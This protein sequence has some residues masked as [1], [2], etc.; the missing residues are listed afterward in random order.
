M[1]IGSSGTRATFLKFGAKVRDKAKQRDAGVEIGTPT[2]ATLFPQL[3]DTTYD[4]SRFMNYFPAGY[5]PFPGINA[6]ASRALFAALPA[7]S[8][9][10]DRGADAESY[11]ADER[12]VAAYAMAELFLGPKLTIVPG[13]RFESTKVNY[14][15]NEVLFDADGDYV[16]TLPLTGGDTYGFAL[17]GLHLRYAIDDR[18]NVR[19]AYTRTLARPNYFDLVPYELVL[20]EDGDI[21]RGNS[22]LRPTT[23]DNLDFMVEHYFASV[24][25]VSGGVF[26]KRLN[27]YIYQFRFQEQNF[28]ELYAVTQPQNGER[29]NL[30]GIEIAFQNRLTFLPGALNGIS[31][32]GNYTFTTSSARFPD[33][34][35][36]SRLPGQSQHLGNLAISYEKSGFTGKA[37]LN[38][39]GRYIDAVGASAAEDVSYD[40]HT[41]LDL[42]FG[43]RLT[44]NIR[45][46]ADVLNLTNAPL[47][48]YIG[49]P[50]RPIQEE[51]YRWWTSFGVKV[52][53]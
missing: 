16:S 51:Y 25:V 9:V 49:T 52:N 41:Q 6:A 24:G 1:P 42:N 38:F 29:A 14:V 45:V 4:N 47:R 53:W 3:E 23:S 12:V 20:Q 31:L 32:Y 39:H 33:R 18:T 26:Y 21:S 19:A 22:S 10:R 35:G 28:G 50:D 15:G 40:N 48:Y 2:S 13:L 46:Y 34:S 43:Q 36:D 8:V 27:D 7:S 44:R 5:A 11:T 17:P 37:A 30:S